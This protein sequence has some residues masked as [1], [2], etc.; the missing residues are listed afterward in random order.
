MPDFIRR[1]VSTSR[2]RYFSDLATGMENFGN[3]VRYVALPVALGMFL[4]SSFNESVPDNMVTESLAN[5]AYAFGAG[6]VIRSAGYLLREARDKSL[7][8]P[9]AVGAAVRAA[10]PFW[11]A[12]NVA[13]GSENVR[14]AM[15]DIF[16]AMVAWGL[17][18][19]TDTKRK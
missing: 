8:I 1:G 16:P 13:G 2:E 11:L 9:K 5:P 19:A 12:Y 7:T 3:D 17:G 6:E 15:A 4:K 10:S 18:H 14:E